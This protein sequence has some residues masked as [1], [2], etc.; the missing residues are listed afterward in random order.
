[1]I[2]A[3]VLQYF[4][5]DGISV[6]FD[7]P[8]FE[9]DMR[10]LAMDI[11]PILSNIKIPD[12]INKVSLGIKDGMTS[13][14]IATFSA[15]VCAAMISTHPEYDEMAARIGLHSLHLE[16]LSDF[17]KTME[18]Q[19]Q[20]V[21]P[22]KKTPTNYLS[23]RFMNAINSNKERIQS[24]IDY[25]RDF[26]ISYFGFKTFKHGY[27][28]KKNGVAAERP[29]HLFMKTAIGIWA[30]D[31][32]MA[33]KTYDIMSLG[34]G[35]HAT[36]TLFN[37]ATVKNQMS[38]CF[39]ASG[40]SEMDS[41]EGILKMIKWVGLT[42]K[43]AGGVCMSVGHIRAAQS[44]IVGT[45]GTASGL[46]PLLKVF[47]AE[48]CYI[49]QCFA[50]D[51]PIKTLHGW[52]TI[53]SLKEGQTVM[54]RDGKVRPIKKVLVY[55]PSKEQRKM[56]SISCSF[57][58]ERVK[59]T[60]SHTFYVL[61]LPVCEQRI[62][63]NELI[64]HMMDVGIYEFEWVEARN[65]KVGD[66][67]VFPKECLPPRPTSHHEYKNYTLYPIQNIDSS[68]YCGAVYD[69]EI[70]EVESTDPTYVTPTGIVH[71]GGGKR[72]GSVAISIE[73]WH[74]DIFDFINMKGL[75]KK[76]DMLAKNL[77]YCVWTP[78]LFMKRVE[79]HESWS[80]FSPDDAPGLD[81]CWGEEFEKLYAKYEATPGLARKVIKAEDLWFLITESKKETSAPYIMFKD[82]CNRYSNQQNLGTIKCTNLC[83]EILQ[84]SGP[85]EVA[86]CNLASVSL[87]A[88]L[89]ISDTKNG[90]HVYQFDHQKLYDIVHGLALNLDH[91]ID[92]NYYALKQTKK[93]NFRHR[94]MGIG[95]QGMA[96][97]FIMM[98]LPYDSQEARTLNRE[99]FETM[100]YSAVRTS[101][102][103]AQ[104]HGHYESYKEG[105]GSPLSNGKFCFDLYNVTPSK[106]W[107]W[108]SLRSEV[109]RYGVRNSLFIAVMPTA[110][111]AQMLG[112]SE[113]CAP[114][115]SNLVIRNVL[116]GNF[117]VIEKTLISALMD[118]GLWDEDMRQ[119]L[120]MNRGSVQNITRIPEDIKLLFRTVWEIPQKHIL[121]MAADRAPFIDQGQSTSLYFADCSMKKIDSALFYAW[122]KG[123]KTGMYYLYTLPAE[124]P[125]PITLSSD[126]LEKILSKSDSPSPVVGRAPTLNLAPST[127]LKRK[128]SNLVDVPAPKK[129]RSQPRLTSQKRKQLWMEL[130]SNKK[131]KSIDDI[132][133]M[134]KES[135]FSDPIIQGD[136]LSDLADVIELVGT[137]PRQNVLDSIEPQAC[138][139]ANPG[140][141]S[142]AM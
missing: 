85:D 24:K 59:V 87:P 114:I 13:G 61:R 9:N 11:N 57:S 37:A 12:I 98:G 63:S 82:A 14:E 107:D 138:F 110:T 126:R 123:L 40:N 133:D 84:W 108:T 67:V 41:M 22:S 48:A 97:M 17:H 6:P 7:I 137:K 120:I 88:C 91:I 128:R 23:D 101:C 39:L 8:L 73:P 21:H 19:S 127:P 64:M 105:K 70:D 122:K 69:L 5:R 44:Y 4:N 71:N 112:N 2:T 58:N 113:E 95:V 79:N 90:R 54:T 60:D 141:E 134:F 42:L 80:L 36:P 56:Y 119:D 26:R 65:L 106:R 136:G 53:S 25:S 32:E 99:I 93:S 1:M 46:M 62:L 109:A 102:T 27:L 49:D 132:T 129:S 104:K 31:I 124:T 38:S 140:C 117:A 94:P 100:Y 51:T 15:E 116:A 77:F 55:E 50:E 131:I 103:L 86:V 76:K 92:I 130:A 52:K 3:P 66:Y 111:T 78:D 47:D 135:E 118:K 33:F 43:S 125:I 18:M 115:T 96:K 29:Q 121:Q 142:C 81:E 34:L 72:K 83:T 10:S 68:A 28:F 35:M 75:F 16:T 45:N 20:F 89:T 74:A 30:E 139:L